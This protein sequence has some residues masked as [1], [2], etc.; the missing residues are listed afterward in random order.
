MSVLLNDLR[1]NEAIKSAF[2]FGEYHH[3]SFVDGY[4]KDPLDLSFIN[5]GSH[6]ELEIKH[7]KPSVEDCFIHLMSKEQT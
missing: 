7:V 4:K 2:S 1:E 3:V 6:R 5:G